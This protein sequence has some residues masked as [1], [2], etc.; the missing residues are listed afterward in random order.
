MVELR[1]ITVPSGLKINDLV[2]W[3]RVLLTV[4]IGPVPEWILDERRATP[5]HV[6]GIS[7]IVEGPGTIHTFYRATLAA[8]DLRALKWSFQDRGMW[9]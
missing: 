8:N 7:E 1:K 9:L 3:E 6:D 4:P 2:E 5:G